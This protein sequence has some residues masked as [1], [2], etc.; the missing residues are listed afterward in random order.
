MY[1]REALH[2]QFHTTH[3]NSS[4]I[5]FPSVRYFTFCLHR[6]QPNPTTLSLQTPSPV[7][8]TI[9]SQEPGELVGIETRLSSCQRN[10][11]LLA[12]LQ[13]LS[14]TS[15]LLGPAVAQFV[16]R[17]LEPLI[18]GS[19]TGTIPVQV[20]PHKTGL[21]TDSVAK[22]FH[23]L[24]QSFSSTQVNVPI[25][26]VFGQTQRGEAKQE[27]ASVYTHPPQANATSTTIANASQ[28][29]LEQKI[30]SPKQEPYKFYST[31]PVFTDTK[32]NAPNLFVNSGQ[33][34]AEAEQPEKPAVLCISSER[35]DAVATGPSNPQA[36][37][38]GGHNSMQPKPTT[39]WI[40]LGVPQ[41]ATPTRFSA[42]VHVDVGGTLYTSSLETLT[43][44][45]TKLLDRL[46][47]ALKGRRL[48]NDH[49]LREASTGQHHSKRYLV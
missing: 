25:S 7:M 31:L 47:S 36:I 38:H 4:N 42:P 5:F 27:L 26:G 21:P 43:K 45:V 14:S 1:R 49:V 24:A 12:L 22:L 19:E 30:A 11:E 9:L 2:L 48:M 18:S 28:S 35:M 16:P 29:E 44:W 6:M 33:T 23:S 17:L 20:D 8:S 37:K 13:S 10:A 15:F 3:G 34:A 40:K 39:N 32:S 41:P 46:T